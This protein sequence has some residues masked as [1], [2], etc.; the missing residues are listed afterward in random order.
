MI[1][2]IALTLLA[3]VCLYVSLALTGA[4]ANQ[5]KSVRELMEDLKSTNGRQVYDA[6]QALGEMG[7]QIQPALAQLIDFLRNSE[8][9]FVVT[10]FRSPQSIIGPS[11]KFTYAERART[12]LV[13]AGA[14]AIP[15][16]VKAMAEDSRPLQH[17]AVLVLGALAGEKRLGDDRTRKAVSAYLQKNAGN[18]SVDDL[19]VI[20]FTKVPEVG[21]ELIHRLQNH[22]N[23]GTR[24]WSALRLGELK[25][26]EAIPPLKTALAGD[27][28]YLVRQFSAQALGFLE[29]PAIKSAALSEALLNDKEMNVREACARSLQGSRSPEAIEA[30]VKAVNDESAEVRLSAAKAFWQVKAHASVPALM[31]A[32]RNESAYLTRDYIMH[33]LARQSAKEALP[34]IEEVLQDPSKRASHST[35]KFAQDVLTGVRTLNESEIA[36]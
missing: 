34:L 1:R 10:D 4:E 24:A 9:S 15:S 18:L 32:L 19:R 12:T 22:T 26:A 7:T 21:R 13:R 33:A 14:V 8:K 31:K 3:L 23:Y 29:Q 5:T 17:N 30:L 25:V 35:A 16:L 20:G 2:R 11:Q 6:F 27:P 28:N 36:Q